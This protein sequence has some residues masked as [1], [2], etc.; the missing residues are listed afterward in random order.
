MNIFSWWHRN[1]CDF[2]TKVLQKL[3][4]SYRMDWMDLNQNYEN[5]NHD[6]QKEIEILINLTLVEWIHLQKFIGVFKRKKFKTGFDDFLSQKLQKKNVKCWLRSKFNWFKTDK[7]QKSN[8]PLWKGSFKCI[9]KNCENTFDSILIMYDNDNDINRF[10]CTIKVK[11]K[12][13]SIHKENIIK[14]QRMTGTE[15]EKEAIKL[16][17]HVV[18][19][20]QII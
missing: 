14:K 18:T 11:C 17:A 10:Y 7:S 5:Q 15:R 3:N 12:L 6:S 9:D 13:V 20:I 1:T 2:Q 4:E 16:K 8:S 19:N